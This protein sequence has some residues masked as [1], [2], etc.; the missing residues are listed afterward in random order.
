M[1]KLGRWDGKTHLNIP[2]V[3]AEQILSPRH[4]T[5]TVV[6]E[7]LGARAPMANT[8]LSF[9]CWGKNAS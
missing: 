9:V 1:E 7:A 3:Y 4:C 6:L 2:Q 8:I 5:T